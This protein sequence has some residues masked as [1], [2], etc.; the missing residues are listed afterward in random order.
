MR[1]NRELNCIDAQMFFGGSA[2]V[3]AR[4]RKDSLIE[5]ARVSLDNRLRVYEI[6]AAGN[7]K[8]LLDKPLKDDGDEFVRYKNY[9]PLKPYTSADWK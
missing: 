5:F 6:D 3:F 4:I 9:K 7:E 2:T 1:Y 8:L